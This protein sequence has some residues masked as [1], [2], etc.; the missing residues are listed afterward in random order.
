MKIGKTGKTTIK[1]IA[2][3][4]LIVISLLVSLSASSLRY[5]GRDN[6]RLQKQLTEKLTKV[7]VVWATVKVVSGV[8]SVVKTI[9][10]EGS[11]PVVGGLAVSAQP[12]GWA[13]VIDN[14]LDKISTLLLWA[15]GAITIEKL[16]LAVSVWVSLKIVIPL[17][18]VFVVITI[19]YKKY[20]EQLKRIIAGII[21]IGLSISLAIP[22]SL[23]LSN[24]IETSILSSQI[25]KT[26][27]E[28]EGQS[29][30]IEKEGDVDTSL[31]RQIGASIAN[32]FSGLKQKFDSFIENTIN[33][34]MCFI[35]TSL[36]IPVIT[37]FGLKYLVGVTLRFIG[38][39]AKG[40]AVIRFLPGKKEKLEIT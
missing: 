37:L 38:F 4:L 24:V 6:S 18:A 5:D 3:V 39:P 33:Y 32:F 12:L 8:I 14:I 17:C 40:D 26:M 13:D 27:N 1:I 22:L 10:V 35:V 25:N 29:R 31:L 7:A 23:G 36:L 15:M 16:L 19:W 28:L 11:I 30:E 9:Q 21:I 2:S 34:I 20:Q